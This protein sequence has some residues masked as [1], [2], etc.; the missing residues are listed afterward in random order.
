MRSP[1][2]EKCQDFAKVMRKRSELIRVV[3]AERRS[4]AEQRLAELAL[5]LP[6]A[7]QHKKRV[8]GVPLELRLEQEEFCWRA[9]HT[10]RQSLRL[11]WEGAFRRGSFTHMDF[12]TWQQRVWWLL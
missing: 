7:D 1:D 11:V 12:D 6:K 4:I 5:I 8:D 10:Q 2:I 3:V 9:T